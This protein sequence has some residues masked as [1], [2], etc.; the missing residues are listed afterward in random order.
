[1]LLGLEL[2]E[3]L[4]PPLCA[5]VLSIPAL[6]DGEGDGEDSL[7]AISAVSSVARSCSSAKV[8]IT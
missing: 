7:G 5:V 1:M 8:G 6:G 3:A 4:G 2:A